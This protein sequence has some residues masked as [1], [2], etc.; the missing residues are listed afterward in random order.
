MLETGQV[1]DR[2]RDFSLNTNLCYT[3]FLNHVN[4]LSYKNFDA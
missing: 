3:K 1:G 4:A 2:S